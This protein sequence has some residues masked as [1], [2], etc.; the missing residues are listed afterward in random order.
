MTIRRFPGVLLDPCVRAVSIPS[1]WFGLAAKRLTL[2]GFFV[3][4]AIARCVAADDVPA[5]VVAGWKSLQAS[6][7][8]ASASWK[9]ESHMEG[10]PDIEETYEFAKQDG[11]W[12]SFRRVQEGEETWEYVRLDRPPSLYTLR[13]KEG[14]RWQ[15]AKVNRDSRPSGDREDFY[16]SESALCFRGI[17][18][19]DD[20]ERRGFNCVSDVMRGPMRE[21]VLEANRENFFSMK[22][23]TLLVDP[24]H[25]FRVV[26]SEC[27]QEIQGRSGVLKEEF[28]YE[29]GVSRSMPTRIRGEVAG[30]EGDGSFQE[31]GNG[32]VELKGLTHER[33]PEE[34]FTL[35][36]Y[37]LSEPGIT[38]SSWE[39]WGW[40]LLG[41]IGLLVAV[42]TGRR[43]LRST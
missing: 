13:R 20:D 42:A 39:F 33:L 6:A 3:I 40:L 4:V 41:I 9:H 19:A 14:G 8:V 21:L 37:G 18:L 27:L 15:I 10:A 11:F 38:G 28:Q 26:R 36:F 22:R 12:K 7:V 29:D 5:E 1:T 17:H 43:M 34:Q 25:D 2:C 31:V 24:A 32:V 23:L 16:T 30:R 35:A